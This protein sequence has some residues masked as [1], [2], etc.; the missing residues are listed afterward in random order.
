MS[1]APHNDP[2]SATPD[3]AVL[4]LADRCLT[5]DQEIHDAAVLCRAGNIQA[6]G[7]ASAFR[8]VTDVP[9]VRL[10]GCC[11]VPGLVDTHLH[12]SGPVSVMNMAGPDN[13]RE[14]ART[15]ARHG[16]TTF[17]PT[18]ITAPRDQ[19]IQAVARLAAACREF[20]DGAEPAGLHLEGPYISHSMRGTQP[21][22]VR[23]VDLGEVKELLAA[24]LGRVR[25]MTF[26][27][28]RKGAE[29][30]VQTL[31]ERNVVPSMGHTEAD[32]ATAVR[33]VEAGATRC[34]H[35]FNGM[36]PLHHRSES[37]TTVAL[38]DDRLCVELNPD[39][40][41]VHSRMIRLVMRAKSHRQVVAISDSVQGAGLG[42]GVYHL[43]TDEIRIRNGASRRI[44][45][46]RL[47][48]SC[49]TLDQA[50]R[51]LMHIAGLPPT[52]ATACCTRNAAESVGLNDRGEIRPG[53]RADITVLDRDG[54][55]YATIVRGRFVYSAE[56]R[57]AN[58]R[59]AQ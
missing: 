34:T 22:C 24:G 43:G 53:K 45:D 4:L 29:D 18:L 26:A 38:T 50:L 27:P 20:D 37:I 15:L 39:G 10:S 9:V 25:I 31:I 33:L 14:M 40:V 16:V 5:P 48:G 41:H 44:S 21:E 17:L 32:A 7:S 1:A 46:G 36:P 12:G 54:R 6:V 3:N 13:L 28:E 59:G 8:D 56:G 47:A 55:V 58:C 51:N 19:L 42:D 11:L 57:I 23:D 52:E 49:I 30:L 35:L 2:Q